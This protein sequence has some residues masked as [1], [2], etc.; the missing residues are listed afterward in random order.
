[1]GLRSYKKFQALLK[2]KVFPKAMGFT[3]SAAD[4]NRLS[5][6]LKVAVSFEGIKLKD[7]SEK[8][9]IGY[10]AFFQVIL[11]YSAFENFTQ[12]LGYKKVYDPELEQKFLEKQNPVTLLETL[13]QNDPDWKLIDFLHEKVN[14][15]LKIKLMAIKN[16]ETQNLIPLATAIRHIFAHGHL[17]ANANKINPIKVAK[18]CRAISDSLLKFMD[19]EFSEKVDDCYEKYKYKIKDKSQT[20]RD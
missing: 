3:G 2:V 14:D 19:D 9:I 20:I 6:R 16:K 12:I 11:T 8:T 10:N 15:K 4:I 5:S 17:S 18:I 13:Y 1:M 7:T